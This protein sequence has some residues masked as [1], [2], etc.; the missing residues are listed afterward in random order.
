MRGRG[1][2]QFLTNHRDSEKHNYHSCMKIN[3]HVD[4]VVPP[5]Q[6]AL[7]LFCI[8]FSNNLSN[9]YS[10]YG[11]TLCIKDKFGG[12]K[13]KKEH[14]SASLLSRTN[15]GDMVLSPEQQMEASEGRF[16]FGSV[17]TGLW[18]KVS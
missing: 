16:T 4:P 1:K 2:A 3:C 6:H 18:P 17:K 15:P 8:E 7:V 13:E 12:S 14:C 10:F 5:R 9:T 11:D